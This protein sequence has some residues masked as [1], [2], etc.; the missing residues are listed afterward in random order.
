VFE[1]KLGDVLVEQVFQ[2]KTVINLHEIHL[3]IN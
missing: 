3:K 1:V 2:R